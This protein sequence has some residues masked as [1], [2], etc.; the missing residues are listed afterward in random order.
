MALFGWHPQVGL[1]FQN[2]TPKLR[3]ATRQLKINQNSTEEQKI[4]QESKKCPLDG[5]E[6]L[7]VTQKEKFQQT[8]SHSLGES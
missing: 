5:V 4:Q 2:E 7:K 6:N 3:R 8:C 1:Y